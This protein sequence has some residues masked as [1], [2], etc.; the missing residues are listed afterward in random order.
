M[1]E[2]HAR[3][4]TAHGQRRLSP[5]TGS[6]GEGNPAANK[7]DSYLTMPPLLEGVG[8]DYSQF[9][10]CAEK[11]ITSDMSANYNDVVERTA[12]LTPIERAALVLSLAH[13]IQED[14]AKT[15]RLLEHSV[16]A[17]QH[18]MHLNK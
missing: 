5:P 15:L 3:A 11:Y 17:A 9:V 14:Q 13:M 8:I 1:E 7:R 2:S 12:M 18:L 4:F 6:G 10:R 16:I